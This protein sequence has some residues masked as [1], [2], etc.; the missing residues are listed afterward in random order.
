M[1]RLHPTAEKTPG[2]V[3][4]EAVPLLKQARTFL[5]SAN[6]SKNEKLTFWRG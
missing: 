5:K 4:L 1:L 3:G 6:N 2:V